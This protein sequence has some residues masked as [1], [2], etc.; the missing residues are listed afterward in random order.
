MRVDVNTEVSPILGTE[1]QS[2][3]MVNFISEQCENAPERI[4][5]TNIFGK[6]L[7]ELVCG[8]LNDKITSM[9]KEAQTKMRKTV[10]RIVN[11][12]RGGVICILL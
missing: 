12:N 7:N 4:W 6:T 2:E 3:D 1:K 5:E 10:T 9:P 11:E 8:N